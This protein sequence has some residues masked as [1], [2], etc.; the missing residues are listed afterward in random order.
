MAQQPAAGSPTTQATRVPAVD[1]WFVAPGL[2]V[3]DGV[4]DA[5]TAGG[6]R[7][8]GSR[9]EVCGTYAF[10][11]RTGPC[12]NPSC[13]AAE[14]APT[15]LSARGT[16]WSYTENHYAPPAPYVAADPFEPYALAAVELVDEGLVVLGQVAS[17]VG[18][19][20]LQVGMAMRLGVQ[21]LFTDDDGTEHVV[22]VWEP[23]RG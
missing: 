16:V 14:L 13:T 7:L 15:L 11:P 23:D 9:C 19:A 17:G 1:G 18:A 22:W 4:T 8:V 12:P 21:V 20:D 2:P 6:P 5:D 3:P 10:P